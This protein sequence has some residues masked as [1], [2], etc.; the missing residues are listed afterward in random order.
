MIGVNTN[1][2]NSSLIGNDLGFGEKSLQTSKSS[3]LLC[4]YYSLLQCVKVYYSVLKFIT[5][6][7]SLLQCI[8][9]FETLSLVS[10]LDSTSRGNW[11]WQVAAEQEEQRSW[12]LQASRAHAQLARLSHRQHSS[13]LFLF[14]H[15]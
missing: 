6:Y 9:V 15:R 3:T 4:V 7:Y 5:V 8:R 14:R 10:P 13:S 2:L 12:Y 11:F 1:T